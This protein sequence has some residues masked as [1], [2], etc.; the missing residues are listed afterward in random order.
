MTLSPEISVLWGAL[1]ILPPPPWPQVYGTEKKTGQWEG[2]AQLD[3]YGYEWDLPAPGH[4]ALK[5]P[6]D[7]LW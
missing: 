6:W 2:E 1:P 7:G 5:K 4:G 3:V